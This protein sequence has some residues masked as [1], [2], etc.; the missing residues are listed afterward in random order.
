MEETPDIR[1]VGPGDA[2]RISELVHASFLELAAKDWEPNAVETFL[3][4]SSPRSVMAALDAAAYAAAEFLNE[5]PVGFLLM[6]EPRVLS[7]LF[8]HPRHLRRG[9]ARR[10]WQAARSFIG[11]DYPDVQTVETNSTPCA[12]PAYRA[13]GFVPISD[14]FLRGGCRATRMACWLPARGLGAECVRSSPL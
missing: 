11:A 13:L 6:S 9:I 10:L 14:E 2:E 1:R 8:V 12:L 4:E 7:M 5:K 3:V